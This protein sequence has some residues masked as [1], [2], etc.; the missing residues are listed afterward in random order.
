MKVAIVSNQAPFVRG[1][2][3]L[4]AEW[5]HDMLE[6]HGHQAE[7]VRIPFKWSP[8]EKIIDHMLAARLVRV[9]NTDRVV[10]LKFPAYFVPHEDKV[11]WLVHQ[12]RQAYD[13]WG[14]PYQDLPQTPAGRRIRE[15]VMQ[16]D[17]SFLPEAGSKYAISRTVQQRLKRYCDLESDVLYPPVLDSSIYRCR[18]Y[19]DYFL[20]PGRITAGKRQDLAIA[21][22]EHVPGVSRLVIAGPPETPQDLRRLQLIVHERGLEKRVEIIP[23]WISEEEKIELFGG[24]RA[25][26]YLPLDEDYGLVTL[27]AFHSRKPVVTLEDSGGV[28]ELVRD[29]VTGI[30]AS[31]MRTLATALHELAEING[32]A[33]RLGTAASEAPSALGISWE[34]VIRELTR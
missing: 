23:R 19:G 7:I 15:S 18:E 5:L 6:E 11:L 31:D 14:T 1:G 30:V 2:A 10:A 32:L 16:A 26:V 4:L 24:A 8:P 29:R 13:L 25:V 34:R 21:A 20:C 33:E 12:F 27:E 9:V 28:L 22:M 3:E 17:R